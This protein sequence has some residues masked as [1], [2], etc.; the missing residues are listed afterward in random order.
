MQ[1]QFV[2]EASGI[3]TTPQA[4]VNVISRRV[5]ELLHGHNSLVEVKPHMGL[6]DIALREV[7]EGKLGYMLTTAVPRRGSLPQIAELPAFTP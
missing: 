6:A 2:E 3:I 7:I 5:R 1:I 4:L